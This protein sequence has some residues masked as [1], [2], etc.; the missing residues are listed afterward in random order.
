M[1]SRRAFSMVE[2]FVVIA[3]FGILLALLGPAVSAARESA[4]A[5]KCLSNLRQIGMATHQYED[6]NRMYPGWRQFSGA[7][8]NDCSIHAQLLPFMDQSELYEQLNLSF[9][10]IPDEDESSAPEWNMLATVMKRQLSIFLCPSDSGRL[11]PG[12]NYRGCLG[13]GP[14]Y[15]FNGEFPDS[16]N[17]FFCPV[18]DQPGGQFPIRTSAIS[19]GLSQTAMFSERLRG[20]GNIERFDPSRD[21]TLLRSDP[22]T[23]DATM[24]R[25]R[26]QHEAA[27]EGSWGW[28]PWLGRTWL[29]SGLSQTLYNHVLPPNSAIADCGGGGDWVGPTTARS[30]HPG[31]VNVLF[32]DGSSRFVG[33]AVA[34]NV[35]RSIAT[36]NGGEIVLAG[37]Y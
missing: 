28:N 25:C 6:V 8:P 30:G 32:G 17:G 1:K 7:I 10:R 2:L 12:S 33:D 27:L 22:S 24:A 31:G 16:G 19:D 20:S 5:A 14:M 18:Y 34:L 23:A 26:A 21:A 36:R 35:W 11:S 13:S 15:K 37:S 3:I 4:R 9:C 29:L